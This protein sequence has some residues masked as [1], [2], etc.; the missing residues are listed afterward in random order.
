MF[1]EWL[2]TECLLLFSLI[3]LVFRADAVMHSCLSV[4]RKVIAAGI[5]VVRQRVAT[6]GRDD[7]YCFFPAHTLCGK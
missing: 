2:F 6:S 5:R 7:F 4:S 3:V 1:F